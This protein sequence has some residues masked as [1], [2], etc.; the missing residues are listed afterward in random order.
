MLCS[1]AC[2]RMCGGMGV[3]IAGCIDN[4]QHEDEL[5]SYVYLCGSAA[6]SASRAHATAICYMLI[7]YM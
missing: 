6:A 7:R 3:A 2:A 1:P 5:S 4:A